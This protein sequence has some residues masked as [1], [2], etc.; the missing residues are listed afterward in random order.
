METR[1]RQA[2]PTYIYAD[3]E[4][5]AEAVM[6]RLRE[7]H[8]SGRVQ[9]VRRRVRRAGLITASAVVAGLCIL[10]S[11][12]VNP[13]MANALNNLPLVGSLFEQAGDTGL[14]TAAEQGLT[15][16]VNA[17]QTHDGVTFKISEMMYDGTRMSMVLT[18]ETNDGDNP[19]LKEWSD[20]TTKETIATWKNQGKEASNIELR[21]NGK[22]LNVTTALASDILHNNSSILTVQ[23]YVAETHTTSFDLPDSFNLEVV[24]R[25]A[26]IGRY[27]TL[28]FPVEKTTSQTIV[29]A[30]AETKSYNGLVMRIKKLELTEATS[31][32][33]VYLTGKAEAE[34]EE[35]GDS[36]MY[37]IQNERGESADIMGGSGSAGADLGNYVN[38]IEFTPFPSLPKTVTV[39]PFLWKGTDKEYIPELAFTLP[40]NK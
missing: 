17:S 29:L 19:P 20:V 24:I 34:L 5:T 23:P 21:A 16:K 32:L 28:S 13:A 4:R 8:S 31:Q 36:L 26:T 22:K 1:I 2:K 18:R 39:K 6:A 3:P 10:G 40:V 11:G 7:L 30:S 25:D 14:K 37:D 15:A 38:T 9:P 35:L 27:F 33:E 12:F